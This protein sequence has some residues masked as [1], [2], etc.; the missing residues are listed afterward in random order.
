V[1]K[2]RRAAKKQSADP[3]SRERLI[4]KMR[5]DCWPVLSD[6]LEGYHQRGSR[7]ALDDMVVLAE[8]WERELPLWAVRSLAE[9]LRRRASGE[10]PKKKMG[11]HATY[12]A[13]FEQYFFD[14]T[15]Y[16][17]VIDLRRE[18]VKWREIYVALGK[19]FNV[20]A[21]V[22]RKTYSRAKKKLKLDNF[23][24]A[25]LPSMYNTTH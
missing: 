5:E 18:K 6:K 20:D 10:K 17:R 9:G 13:E 21:D 19:E 16:S 2:K 7:E 3:N 25:Y 24:L 22:I 12:R 23:Y 8:S 14:V 4:A 1:A 11:R 15:V